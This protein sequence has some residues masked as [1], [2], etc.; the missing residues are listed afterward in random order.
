MSRT[1]KILLAT[2]LVGGLLFVL[3]QWLNN[4]NAEGE[5]E[6]TS[7]LNYVLE[8]D[9]GEATTLAD[10]AGWQ[11]TNDLGYII[12]IADGY[13][14]SYSVELIACDNDFTNDPLGTLYDAIMPASAAAGHGDEPDPSRLAEPVIESLNNPQ[15]ISTEPVEL[16]GTTYCWGHYLIGSSA[17][18][19]NYDATNNEASLF[20]AGTYQTAD[21]TEGIP[22][23]I[24]SDIAW[25]NIV[26]ITELDNAIEM[27][28]AGE[29]VTLSITRELD[30]MFNSLD[31]NAMESDEQART[32]LRN[33]TQTT[34]ITVVE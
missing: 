33:L 27:V 29:D 32:V 8:W 13:L 11:L 19:E 4:T 14:I 5:Q 23:E 3:P 31:F 21:S 2:L 25:G 12:T 20:L 15:S 28:T 17:A 9:W 1:Y 30:S 18:S 10:N 26:E 7:T 22:F 6:T 34:T 24:E 16:T